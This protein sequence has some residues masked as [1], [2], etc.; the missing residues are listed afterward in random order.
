MKEDCLELLWGSDTG[1]AFD[2]SRDVGTH[3]GAN[4]RKMEDVRIKTEELSPGTGWLSF[5]SGSSPTKLLRIGFESCQS[6]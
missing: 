1:L 5:D 3:A 2:T 6:Q 4:G